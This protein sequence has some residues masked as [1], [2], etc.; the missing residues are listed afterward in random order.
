MIGIVR[1]DVF[2]TVSG[3]HLLIPKGTKVIG[4][5]DSGVKYGQDRL[6]IVWQ[7]LIFPNGDS[8]ML[9]NFPGV[10]LKGYAGNTGKV[11]NHFP[12]TIKA[13]TLSSIL[14]GI[15]FLSGGREKDAVK[16]IADALGEGA[17][18]QAHTVGEAMIS[19]SLSIKPTIEI[20]AGTR[21][22][23]IV[24]ADLILRPYLR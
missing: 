5:Y 3:N 11:D 7:R 21:F 19:K 23:I 1:E 4:T 2:D 10:D 12:E 17:G 13:V 14:S 16:S 9:D 22:N 24:N 18:K 6:L 20:E 15:K 8:I